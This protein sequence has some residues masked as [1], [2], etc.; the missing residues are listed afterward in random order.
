MHQVV[1]ILY[2]GFELLDMAGPAS[3]FSGA[4]RA[5]EQGK[6]PFYQISL[7]SPGGGE[8]ASSSGITVQTARLDGFRGQRIGTLLIVGAESGPLQ[9]AMAD[10]EL[11]TALPGLTADA[12]RFGSV[13]SGGMVL[14]SLGLRDDCRV[15]TH[16]DACAPFQAHFPRVSVD[17]EAL[18]VRDGRL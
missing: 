1:F 6:A 9:T 3:V 13:C 4:N 5:L 7:A 8:V 2:P 11:R 15:A 12:R 14:A 17:P 10:P 18:Y 16:W